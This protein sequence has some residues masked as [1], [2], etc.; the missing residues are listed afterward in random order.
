MLYFET[1]K[2]DNSTLVLFPNDGL[3]VHE[4]PLCIVRAGLPWFTDSVGLDSESYYPH[5]KHRT[6]QILLTKI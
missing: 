3:S 1:M 2:Q 5:V 6:C 4:G